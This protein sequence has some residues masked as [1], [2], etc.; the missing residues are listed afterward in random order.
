VERMSGFAVRRPRA[1]IIANPA[2]IDIE[3]LSREVRRQELARGWDFSL[4]FETSISETGMAQARDAVAAG[5]SLV[6]AVGGDGTV[7]AVSDGLAGL[8]MTLAI[9]PAGTGNLLAR[10][11]G[12]PLGDPAT[13]LSIAFSGRSR[14][15]DV[16][17]L[18]LTRQDGAIDKH[19]FLV[20]AGMGLDARMIETTKPEL[21]RRV[22]WLAY[23][24]AI[25]RILATPTTLNARYSIDGAPENTATINTLLIGNCGT[26]QGHF[27]LLPAAQ[28]DD[29]RLDY[30]ALRS[31]DN[32]DQSAVARWLWWEN[33]W[34]RR[35]RRARGVRSSMRDTESFRYSQA[36]RLQV[37]LEHPER[38]E[39]DGDDVGDVTG[40]EAWADAGALSVR[41]HESPRRN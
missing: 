4:W 7:R 14:R 5:V 27:R 33:T 23:V 22:G 9:V 35:A 15:I 2:K 31:L 17:R 18:A 1:A 28:L 16:G 25:A 19:S 21:K 32:R 36:S 11:L 30:V 6:I 29:G 39:V 37:W 41:V 26:V 40:V 34:W 13:A 3:A 10:N 24:E 12:I 20:M 8:G 38:F